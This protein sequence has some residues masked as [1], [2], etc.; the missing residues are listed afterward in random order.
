MTEIVERIE[1]LENEMEF[2][3]NKINDITESISNKV[4]AEAKPTAT[5]TRKSLGPTS[6][7]TFQ[8]TMRPRVKEQLESEAPEDTKI[9]GKQVTK[10]YQKYG[11]V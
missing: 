7:N 4:E 1:N 3:K 6:W 11:K 2:V 9:D 10:K 8:K 5:K